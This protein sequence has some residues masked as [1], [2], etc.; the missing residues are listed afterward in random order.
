MSKEIGIWI[1]ENFIEAQ[2][3]FVEIAKPESLD[4]REFPIRQ[5]R[6]EVHYISIFASLNGGRCYLFENSQ[7]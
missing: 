4:G 2:N 6:N 7:R 1:P 5:G 3:H